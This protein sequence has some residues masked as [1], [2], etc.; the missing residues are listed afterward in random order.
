M[1]QN[2]VLPDQDRPW[3]FCDFRVWVVKNNVAPPGPVIVTPK[4]VMDMLAW[5]WEVMTY[6][7]ETGATSAG[8]YRLV[9]MR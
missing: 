1:T 9:V 3:T 7:P 5:P 2:V 8:P 6:N 4:Q